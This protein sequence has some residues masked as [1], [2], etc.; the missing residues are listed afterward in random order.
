MDDIE[1]LIDDNSHLKYHG[2]CKYHDISKLPVTVQQTL[3]LCI[4]LDL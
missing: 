3:K 2:Y 4:Q 1:N